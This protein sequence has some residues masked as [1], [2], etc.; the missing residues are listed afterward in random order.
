MNREAPVQ[1]VRFMPENETYAKLTAEEKFE[2]NISYTMGNLE[3][4]R[5]EMYEAL[6]AEI[7]AVAQALI[8]KTSVPL[9]PNVRDAVNVWKIVEAL[10]KSQISGGLTQIVN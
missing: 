3:V 7:E 2:R 5:L 6:A 4:P 10:R 8:Q 1:L 9:I